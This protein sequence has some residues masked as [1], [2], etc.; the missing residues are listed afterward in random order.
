MSAGRMAIRVTGDVHGVGYRQFCRDAALRLGLAGYAHNEEDGS[1]A[2]VVEG[3]DDKVNE[4]V[5]FLKDNSPGMSR[6]DELTVVSRGP[7]TG[8]A[9]FKIL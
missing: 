3:G 1:V 6:V 5:S 9:G 4:F 2:I 7:A 8:A